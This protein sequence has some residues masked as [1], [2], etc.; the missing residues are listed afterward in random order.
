MEQKCHIL[1][2]FWLQMTIFKTSE[3]CSAPKNDY[4]GQKC[5]FWAQKGPFLGLKT[6]LRPRRTFLFRKM[7]IYGKICFFS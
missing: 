7:A 4:L 2:L 1:S 3:G 6:L 5:A